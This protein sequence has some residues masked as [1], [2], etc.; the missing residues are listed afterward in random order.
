MQFTF[1]RLKLTIIVFSSSFFSI[2]LSRY[3]RIKEIDVKRPPRPPAYAFITFEDSLDAEDAVRGRDGYKYDGF[4][5]RCEF[6]K[7][8]RRN[9]A[10]RRDDRRDNRRED[11][12][13]DRRRGATTV[14]RSDY[15]VIVKN[16]PR[17]CT[18]QDLKDH[19]RKA[20]DVIFTDVNKYGEGIVEFANRDDM[21]KALDKLD[22]SELKSL[23]DSSY[24]RLESKNKQSEE[25]DTRG[26]D[27]SYSRSRSRDR[28]YSRSRSP[29]R[30]RSRDRGDR[31]PSRSRSNSYHEENGD[32]V[33]QVQGKEE[34]EKEVQNEVQPGS[35]VV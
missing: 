18:W 1:E 19:M 34:G 3:G 32:N 12:R 31:S 24:I 17:G 9:G 8:E 7:G 11:R 14:R 33:Q 13:D 4:R 23:H 30:S 28:S 35:P 21:D 20:G 5:L 10:D 15:A 22:D 29:S 26:R 6:S 25:R 27:R 2:S 16:L